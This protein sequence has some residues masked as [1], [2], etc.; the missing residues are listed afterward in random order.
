MYLKNTKTGQKAKFSRPQGEDW[1]ECTQEELELDI[2]LK[3]KRELIEKRNRYL[4]S[5]IDKSE[6]ARQEIEQIEQCTI[7]EELNNFNNN[8]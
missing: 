3:K 5:K 2:L 6:Q 7:L 1:E 4:E 8:F